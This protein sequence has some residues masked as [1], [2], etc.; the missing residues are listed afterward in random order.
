ML[1]AG[2]TLNIFLLTGV[3]NIN[4]VFIKKKNNVV[5]D[6]NLYDWLASKI[7]TYKVKKKRHFT[8]K[9]IK[10]QHNR[11]LFERVE[12]AC[13]LPGSGQNHP[14]PLLLPPHVQIEEDLLNG[15][16]CGG[17]NSYYSET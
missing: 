4:I 5:A 16:P 2:E 1:V 7:L 14:L 6:K 17:K 3:S 11:F 15:G 9:F 13:P 12:D 8:N 10:N